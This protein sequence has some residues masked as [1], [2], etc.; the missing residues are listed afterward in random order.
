MRLVYVNQRHFTALYEVASDPFIMQ[1]VGNGQPWTRPKLRDL[2]RASDE[3]RKTPPRARS[4]FCWACM[5]KDKAIG[6]MAIHQMS[7]ASK[8]ADF[9]VTLFLHR[10]YLRK[11]YGTATLRIAIKRFGKLRPDVDAVFADTRLDN[12]RTRQIKGKADFTFVTFV[13]IGE[14]IYKRSVYRLISPSTS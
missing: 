10:D 1:W 4:H 2:I 6:L 11:G 14:K 7:Q 3:A 13:T 12:A 8:N 5:E 9:F